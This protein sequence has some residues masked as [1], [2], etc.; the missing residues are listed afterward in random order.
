MF[1]DIGY[2]SISDIWKKYGKNM[3]KHES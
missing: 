1:I 2:I 3:E